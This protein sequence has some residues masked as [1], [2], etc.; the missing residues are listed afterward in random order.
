MVSET[1]RPFQS[2]VLPNAFC[3]VV[4]E[5]RLLKNLA[6]HLVGSVGVAEQVVI[7]TYTGWYTMPAIQQD[8]IES[9]F[10]W[11]VGTL[12]RICIGL[13]E[14]SPP[15]AGGQTADPTGRPH[16]ADPPPQRWGPWRAAPVL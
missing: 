2:D 13:L 3:V 5:R 9:P 7:E 10:T 6:Y 4:A 11:L 16:V 14:S 8:R 15:R 12:V 1:R